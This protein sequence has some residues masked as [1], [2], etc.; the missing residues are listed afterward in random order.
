MHIRATAIVIDQFGSILLQQRADTGTQAPPSIAL[1]PGELPTDAA[2]R[3]VRQVTDLV[4]LPVRLAA[5]LFWPEKPAGYLFLCFRCILRGGSVR[6]EGGQ[7]VAGF[8]PFKPRPEP[9]LNI[10]AQQIESALYHAGGPPVWDTVAT[11]FGM[12][13]RGLLGVQQAGWMG[14]NA[15]WQVGATTLMRNSAD[16]VLWVRHDGGWVLPGGTAQAMEAPWETAVRTTHAQ[17]GLTAT[18]TDLLTVRNSPSRHEIQFA[19]SAQ[20]EGTPPAAAYFAPG[21]EPANALPAHA[22]LVAQST[23]GP[24]ETHFRVEQVHVQ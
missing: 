8:V 24:E 9:M 2:A 3:V 11:T 19:F 6:Q 23:P 22:A 14:T 17:T 15:E 16:E 18:L 7:P 20:A 4:V 10:H 5:V 1:R 21:S 12:R 13:L